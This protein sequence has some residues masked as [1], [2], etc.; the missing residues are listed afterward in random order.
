MQEPA[1]LNC[2]IKD[3]ILYGNPSALNS[4]ILQA[5]EQSNALEFIQNF[6]LPISLEESETHSLIREFNILVLYEQQ[7]LREINLEQINQYKQYLRDKIGSS[8]EADERDKRPACKK[9]I[10]L[11]VGFN[12]NCGV[13]GSFLSGGQK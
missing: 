3:N 8:S 2:S 13:R 10:Y 7:I 6:S 11:P 1:L 4:Q 9:D 12:L 5:A